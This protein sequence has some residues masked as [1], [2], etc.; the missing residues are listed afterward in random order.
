MPSHTVASSEGFRRGVTSV[1]SQVQGV[2]AGTS[3]IIGI[4]KGVNS[5]Y[6]IFRLMPS[7]TVARG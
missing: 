2:S 5:S 1:D 4:G 6:V 3:V 7:V